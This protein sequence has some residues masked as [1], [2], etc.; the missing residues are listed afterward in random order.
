MA[1]EEATECHYTQK[2]IVKVRTI[3]KYY[4]EKNNKNL[5]IQSGG[6]FFHKNTKEKW[7][8]VGQLGN[9]WTRIKIAVLQVYTR[10]TQ[11]I[12]TFISNESKHMIC[13]KWQH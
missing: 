13:F 3:M 2:Q 12:N 5:N 9:C 6:R 8:Q 4:Y 7:S 11:V 1:Y 10:H